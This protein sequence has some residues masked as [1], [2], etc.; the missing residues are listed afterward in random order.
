MKHS[1]K[2]YYPSMFKAFEKVIKMRTLRVDPS[3]YSQSALSRGDSFSP[4]K[5]RIVGNNKD[6]PDI[7]LNKVIFNDIGK[8]LM[9]RD[10]YSNM[11]KSPLKA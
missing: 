4:L 10:I 7:D 6:S 8:K 11:N 2:S 5:L 9:D 3:G 1:L